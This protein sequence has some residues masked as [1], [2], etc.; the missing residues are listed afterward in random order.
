MAWLSG[1]DQRVKLTIDQGDITAGLA[2]FPILL[3][4]SASSGRGPDDISFIFDEL[5]SNDNRKKIA[6]TTSDGETE[7][8]VEIEKWNDAG[9]EAWLWVKV[10][11]IASDADTDLYLY[12]DVDHADND[13]YVG[14]CAD[15]SAAT[16]HVWDEDGVN[17]YFKM[18]L[19][20]RDATTSLVRDST[21]NNNDGTK[22]AA[23]KPPL[24][25]SGQIG[26]AQDFDQAG[27]ED[28]LLVPQ[29]DFLFGTGDSWTL[30][31]WIKSDSPDTHRT[32]MGID[33]GLPGRDLWR[34]AHSTLNKIVVTFGDASGTIHTSSSA[35]FPD[36]N[37]HHVV[38]V[39]GGG[40][41]YLYVDGEEEADDVDLSTE[42]STTSDLLSIGCRYFQGAVSAYHQYYDGILDEIRISVDVARTAAWAKATYESGRDDL[43]DW[44]IEEEEPPPVEGNPWYSYAQQQ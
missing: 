25:L 12:Y 21:E 5:I 24:T 36:S 26:E 15:G 44:G 43:L 38:A 22:N 8:Y 19:H 31:A 3:Y 39:V 10:P 42:W 23:N 41:V 18:V 14:D 34:L 37:P 33:Q 17:E 28:W 32:M 40:K 16:H 2:N 4:L 6:V 27:E 9:E 1:W 13:A 35:A 11:A 7:C 29:T 20:M 30:E